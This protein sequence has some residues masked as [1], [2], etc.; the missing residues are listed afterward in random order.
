MY[1][2]GYGIRVPPMT[3]GSEDPAVQRRRLRVEL[4]KLRLDSHRT[5]R[6]VAQAMDWSASKVIRIENGEVGISSNDLKVLLAY[7]EVPEKRLDALLSI[8][9]TSRRDPW[10]AL[11]DV[12]SPA[13]L[14]YLSF[15]SSAKL[16]RSYELTLV[17]GLLQTEEFNL[18]I[19]SG[20]WKE[21]IDSAER[22]WSGRL[23]RQ[24]LHER[25]DPP[26]MFFILD[27]AVLRRRVGGPAVMRRQLERLKQWSAE[28]HVSLQVYPFSAGAYPGMDGGPFTLLEFANPNDDDLLY[29]EYASGAITIRDE[30]ELT[31]PYTERFLELED[32]ALTAGDTVVL[33]DEIIG[34][35]ERGTKPVGVA[36]KV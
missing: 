8:A 15:E 33:I 34:E 27:E 2:N 30:P 5:Q 35:L 31:R 28:P 12:H 29:L 19:Q 23:R 25:D 17:P 6:E 13:F 18:K 9:R 11:R 21:S 24:E 16:I 36:A 20:V 1:G 32:N 22:R 7:Y 3:A 14:R 4:R 26:E 10:S